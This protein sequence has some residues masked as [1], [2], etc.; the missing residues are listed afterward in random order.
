L[1][2]FLVVWFV[3]QRVD[4]GER[5]DA[6]HG[7][8]RTAAGSAGILVTAG[9]VTD[10]TWPMVFDLAAA[11]PRGRFALAPAARTRPLL[12]VLLGMTLLRVEYG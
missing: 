6:G 2:G 8:E 3:D 9:P 12:A 1:R 11:G 10:C 4:Q 7:L 5:T